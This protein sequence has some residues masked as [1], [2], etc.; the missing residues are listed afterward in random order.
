MNLKM[1]KV[2]K[3]LALTLDGNKKYERISNFVST[4]I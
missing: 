3:N 4:Q 1:W 2:G